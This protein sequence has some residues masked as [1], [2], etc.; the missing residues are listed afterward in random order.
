MTRYS[1]SGNAY[2][3]VRVYVERI[4]VRRRLV[5]LVAGVG[6]VGAPILPKGSAA[7]RLSDSSGE[8]LYGRVA[9]CPH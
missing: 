9:P 3:G 6:G 8:I 4:A 5:A 1:K 2:E 7:I